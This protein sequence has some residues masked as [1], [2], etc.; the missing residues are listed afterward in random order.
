MQ[1]ITTEIVQIYKFVDNTR[2]CNDQAFY[3]E[4][5]SFAIMD[6]KTILGSLTWPDGDGDF[7]ERAMADTRMLI[8]WNVIRGMGNKISGWSL[9]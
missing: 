8:V 3:T 5:H 7:L 9:N 1:N 6:L 4:N 2:T